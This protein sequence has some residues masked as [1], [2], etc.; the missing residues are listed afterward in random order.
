M[1]TQLQEILAT[2]GSD[3]K[4]LAKATYYVSDKMPATC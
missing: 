3:L 1:F 2:S 4:H